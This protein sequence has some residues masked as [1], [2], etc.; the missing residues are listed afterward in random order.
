MP[1]VISTTPMITRT[2]FTQAG[3]SAGS[4]STIASVTPSPTASAALIPSI[5]PARKAVALIPG[6]CESSTATMAMTASG[7]T[8]TPIAAVSRLIQ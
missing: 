6:R 2:Q 1:P 8:S 3:A 7:L 4:S 5:Q